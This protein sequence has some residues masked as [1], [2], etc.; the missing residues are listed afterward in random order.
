MAT[1]YTPEYRREPCSFVTTMPSINKHIAGHIA[2][3]PSAK[4]LGASGT[5]LYT[6]Q[7][8]LANRT[9]F[10]LTEELSL[11]NWQKFN[12][13]TYGH[14]ERIG[15]KFCAVL[16]KITRMLLCRWMPTLTSA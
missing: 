2:T 9:V 13:R 8:S 4:L 1:F 12:W 5:C 6:D 15:S 16:S 7:H 11:H 3:T 10:H 14:E